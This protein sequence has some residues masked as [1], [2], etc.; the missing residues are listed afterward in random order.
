MANPISIDT[1]MN[2]TFGQF[3]KLADV[4]WDMVRTRGRQQDRFPVPP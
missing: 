4:F 2:Y 1:E 3:L